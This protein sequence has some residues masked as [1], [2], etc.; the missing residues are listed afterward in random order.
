[1]IRRAERFRSALRAPTSLERALVVS[2]LIHSALF[3]VPAG[4]WSGQREGGTRG[5]TVITATLVRAAVE[6][7]AEESPASGPEPAVVQPTSALIAPPVPDATVPS[8]LAAGGPDTSSRTANQSAGASGAAAGTYPDEPAPV[9][10]GADDATGIPVLPPLPARDRSLP[11]P[12]S[13]LAPMRFSYPTN[14]PMQW[15]RVRVRLLID[16][17]G[18]SLDVRVVSAAPPAVFDDA[19]VQIMK[20]AR[21]APGY[22]GKMAVRSYVYFDLSFGPGPMGQ[23]LWPVGGN[24]A[25]PPGMADAQ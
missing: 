23:R 11:R 22:V 4:D 3:G 8:P 10:A 5:G 24:I 12:A 6:Q 7:A 17:K 1:M 16:D 19:A 18:Q 2:V 14:T 25:L 20:H 13:I 9:H 21:F 15:G